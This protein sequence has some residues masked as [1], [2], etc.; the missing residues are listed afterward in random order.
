MKRAQTQT[1]QSLSWKYIV[2]FFTKFTIEIKRKINS[3]LWL[4]GECFRFY[5]SSSLSLIYFIL[6]IVFITANSCFHL[7]RFHRHRHNSYLKRL[8][9]LK[10]EKNGS[11]SLCAVASRESKATLCQRCGTVK[12]LRKYNFLCFGRIRAQTLSPSM[13]GN[14][15]VTLLSFHNVSGWTFCIKFLYFNCIAVQTRKTETF[16]LWAQNRWKKSNLR[17]EDIAQSFH[18]QS[19]SAKQTRMCERNLK[20]KQKSGFQKR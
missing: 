14:G 6:Y 19:K 1:T 4:F 5:R 11:Y 20:S 8:A 13:A 7:L 16:V 10:C 9:L 2:L 3:L 12:L 17:T 15:S 18:S